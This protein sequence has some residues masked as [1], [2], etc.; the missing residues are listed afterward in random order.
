MKKHMHDII[1]QNEC[2]G[3]IAGKPNKDYAKKVALKYFKDILE[4]TAKTK[5]LFEE[6]CETL[7]EVATNVLKP[8][9]NKTV[10]ENY[11]YMYSQLDTELFYLVE[12]EILAML[13]VF[14]VQVR[15]YE[16]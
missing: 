8:Y 13:N 5:G 15:K 7:L 11:Y 2:Y 6:H 1:I 12:Y 10:E 16:D 4:H 14:S 9:G 3:I